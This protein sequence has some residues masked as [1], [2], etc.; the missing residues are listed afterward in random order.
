GEDE[1]G[2]EIRVP[3]EAGYPLMVA[4]DADQR[5]VP[6]VD[7]V[8]RRPDGGGQAREPAPPTHGTFGERDITGDDGGPEHPFESGGEELAPVLREDPLRQEVVVGAGT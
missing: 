4:Q 3:H 2:V 1:E 8:A 6:Q 7:G 5:E